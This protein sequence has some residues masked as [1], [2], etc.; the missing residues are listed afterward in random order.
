MH[1]FSV[2]AGLGCTSWSFSVLRFF[3]GAITGFL[4]HITTR[5]YHRE[6]NQHIGGCLDDMETGRIKIFMTGFC[7]SILM[8]GLLFRPMQEHKAFH[9]I[10]GREWLW[11]TL[12]FFAIVSALEMLLSV[13][14]FLA[15]FMDPAASAEE[16]FSINK[17]MSQARNVPVHPWNEVENE[18]DLHFL[19]DP[20]NLSKHG[21]SRTRLNSAR[22]DFSESDFHDCQSQM[23]EEQQHQE[24]HHAME[25]NDYGTPPRPLLEIEYGGSE[26]TTTRCNS[27]MDVAEYRNGKTLYP[28]GSPAYVAHGDCEARI[29]ANYLKLCSGNENKARAMYQKTQAWRQENAIWK[30]HRTPHPFYHQIKKAYPHFIHG[31]SKCGMTIVYE[32]PGKMSLK[33]FFRNG[34]GVPDMVRHCWFLME[35]IANCVST[36]KE[37]VN[38]RG[39][40]PGEPLSANWGTMIVM[41]ISGASVSTLSGDV[42]AYLAKAGDVNNNHYPMAMK[43]AFLVNSPWWLAGAFSGFRS[44]LPESVKVDIL[45]ESQSV[46]A[47]R[48]FIDDNQIPKE[49]GG[50]SQYALGEHPYE[51]GL[52]DLAD[53]SRS[54]SEFDEEDVTPVRRN[55]V[56]SDDGL[57]ARPRMRTVSFERTMSGGSNSGDV[58]PWRVDP[59]PKPLRRRALSADRQR[60]SIVG[61]PKMRSIHEEKTLNKSELRGAEELVLGIVTS[62]TFAWSVVQGGAELLLPLWMVTPAMLGGL[63]YTPAQT[64]VAI[65]CSCLLVLWALKTRLARAVAVLPSNSPMRAFRVG[66][67]AQGALFL[68]LPWIVSSVTSVARTESVLNMAFTVVALASLALAKMFGRAGA[69]A[70]HQMAGERFLRKGRQQGFWFKVYGRPESSS[71]A[72]FP[73]SVSI[74][75]EIVGLWLAARSYRWSTLEERPFPFDGGFGL[76]SLAFTS[77]L[78]YLA[79]FALHQNGLGECMYDDMTEQNQKGESRNKCCEV[80]R[81]VA[82][83][84][85][86][87]MASLME[88]ANWSSSQIL[89][90]HSPNRRRLSSRSIHGLTDPPSKLT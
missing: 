54:C 78:V 79:S 57:P 59:P 26:P 81:E 6:D 22:S 66:M 1:V 62:L 51:V 28:D 13:V 3:V 10:T 42:L 48:K 18:A 87:D 16:S 77:A 33:E 84:P 36:R 7:A 61:Q 4:S 25:D 12:F 5:A 34:G 69:S 52:K 15:E 38:A 29:P 11:S 63:S 75:G 8:S 45:S 71:T 47:L 67:G 76:V 32:Q 68:L 46:T 56:V 73:L 37:L 74:C 70:L 17:P 83:V 49:Y 60:A 31:H 20:L 35:Y 9:T 23:S 72:T 90:Y 58:P 89:G 41:D 40:E 86:S 64:G 50:S 44:I 2:G 65:F 82:S 19:F 85:I 21:P 53:E 30:V 80:V 27:E 39:D 43:R 88:E 55:S 14:F 24:Q